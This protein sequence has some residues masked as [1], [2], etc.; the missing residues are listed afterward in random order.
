MTSR[1]LALLGLAACLAALAPDDPKKTPD[2]GTAYQVPYRLTMT[3]HY[4]VRVKVNGKGPFNFLV[5]TGAPYLFVSTEVAKKI[6]LAP[7]PKGEYWTPLDRLDLE[8]GAKLTGLKARVEDPFQLVGMNAMG[9]PGASI[10]GILGFTVLARFKMEFDPTKDRMTWTRL[11][12]NPKEPFVPKNAEI[13]ESAG[14]QAMSAIGPAMKL[15]AV[16]TGKQPEDI[17]HAQGILGIEFDRDLRITAVLADSPAAKAGLKTGDRIKKLSDASVKETKG[18]HDAIANVKAG[19]A[20]K[21][22]VDRDGQPVEATI[23][24]VEGL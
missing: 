8:G 14:I 6:D 11:D 12:F 2:V 17:L 1:P 13:R 3:N 19:D 23:T 15:M 10:D 20:V 9:L 5:D 24:A 4:L 16:F 22:V 18:A 7:P 21:V